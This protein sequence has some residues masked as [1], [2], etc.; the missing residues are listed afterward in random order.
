M[1]ETANRSAAGIPDLLGKSGIAFRTRRYQLEMLTASRQGNVIIAMDTGSGKTHIAVLRIIDELEKWNTEKRIWFLAPTVALCHQQ[2]GVINLEI[3]S[4]KT[5]VL[6]GLDNVD[7]W[8]EQ[9]IWDTVLQDIRV[10]VSTHAMLADALTHGFVRMS[11][12]ALIIFDEAHHCMRHHPANKI[13]QNHYHPARREFG[14][15]AVPHILGLTA[16]PIVRSSSRELQMIEANLDA[17][18]KTPRTH[19]SELLEHVHR[20]HLQTISYSPPRTE[21]QGRGSQLLRPLMRCI[22]SFDLQKDPYIELLRQNPETRERANKILRSGKTYCS[23]QLA[24]FLETSNHIYEE[25]GGW[26]TDYF[27]KDSIDQLRRTRDNN[28]SRSTVDYAEKNSLLRLLLSLPMFE[29]PS[30][31]IHLSP[32]LETLFAFLEKVDHPDFSGLLFAKRRSTVTMLGRVLSMHPATKNRFRSASYVGWSNSSRKEHLGGLLTRDMQ[33]D[34]LSEFRAGQKN[35]IVTTEVLEEGLDVSTCSLVVCYDKPANLKSFVQRRGRARHQRSTYAI[36]TSTK[37]EPLCLKKWQELEQVMI[38]AY[39]NDERRRQEAWDLESINEEVVLSLYVPSTS[40]RMSADDAIQH[41]LHFCAVL[42]VSDYADNLPIRHE[43]AG[44]RHCHLAQFRPSPRPPC[45]R[46]EMVATERAARN[47]TSSLAYKALYVSGLVNENLLPLTRK[48]EELQFI[49][50]IDLP[51]MI[52]C[53]EQYDPYVDLAHAWKTP[54]LH[55][56]TITVSSRDSGAVVE[57][58]SMSIVLPKW[59]AMPD[60]IPLYW[61]PGSD[62]IARFAETESFEATS[63][64]IMSMRNATSIYL[65][66][67]SPRVRCPSWDFVALFVPS[68]SREQLEGWNRLHEGVEKALDLYPRDMS[69]HGVIRNTQN[70][71]G[72]C[73]FRKWE[74]GDDKEIYVECQSIRR[75]RNLLQNAAVGTAMPKIYVMPASSCTVDWLPASKALSGLLIPALLDRLEATLVTKRLNDTILRDVGFQDL[76][77]ILTAITAP[78]AQAVTNYQRYEF[79]GDSILKFT[80]SYQLFFTQPRWHEGY[81]SES[82]DKLVSNK[83]L[84]R[85]ALDTG[86]DSFIIIKRYT[87]HKW[88]APLVSQKSTVSLSERKR[89]LSSKV[90][91]DVIEALIGAAYM[92]GGIHKAQA[93]LQCF[94]PEINTFTKDFAEVAVVTPIDNTSLRAVSGPM[95]HHRL[96]YLIGYTFKSPALL[97]EALTHPSCEHD[98]TTQSYQRLEYLGDAVLDIIVMSELA[99]LP[100]QLSQGNMTRIKHAVVNANFL[101]FLCMDFGV[102][103]ATPNIDIRQT[104][105]GETDFVS[106]VTEIHLWNFL[107]SNGP[108][109]IMAREACSKRYLALLDQIKSVLDHG[110]KYPWELLACLRADK[111]ISDIVESIIGAIFIDSGSLDQCHAFAKRIGLLS[112]MSRIIS[113][114]V[115]VEHPRS[116]AQSLVKRSGILVFETEKVEIRG[117]TAIY[118]SRAIMNKEEIASVEGCGS[119]EEAEIKV[120]HLVIEKVKETS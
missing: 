104:P 113:E 69:P 116:A 8:T 56:T 87:P 115:D 120:S 112:F 19:R 90:M 2:Y 78:V 63:E 45:P 49:E 93:C 40:A 95:D 117:A 13:M 71:R 96:S 83:R 43:R 26:A 33:R 89:Q 23:E 16:S 119:A 91:A 9:A 109:I 84:A 118:R 60:S 86:L 48:S 62:F 94:L 14:P 98:A 29:V 70:Y 53:S 65:Q 21:E 77:H 80:V 31:V 107:R 59:T 110:H 82:R 114:T 72:P 100:L 47:E 5:R 66:S 73:L 103:D 12:L 11:H 30:D 64:V 4:A 34:T 67:L 35:L 105:D 27:I 39:Q 99:S 10:V 55:Q 108:A 54:E 38:T 24:K 41:L 50:E 37:D 25:L 111:F 81:L 32:K 57:D 20:P 92:D 36:M 101:A 6:T 15:H 102:R 18:C 61:E 85:A 68:I 7:R 22:E 88:D 1:D 51:C 74:C 75:R 42:P 3:P 44:P 97:T 76:S 28:T 52:E 17:V 79:F 46:G 58:L 106:H